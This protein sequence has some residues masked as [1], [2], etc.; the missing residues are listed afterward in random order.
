MGGACEMTNNTLAAIGMAIV[1]AS[2]AA[3]LVGLIV[4][5]IAGLR[6]KRAEALRPGRW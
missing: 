3:L 4:L 5:A 1:V 6:K 2:G